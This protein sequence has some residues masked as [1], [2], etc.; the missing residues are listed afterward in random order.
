MSATGDTVVVTGGLVL[1]VGFGS[2][3]GE[4]TVAVFVIVPL[5]GAVTVNVRLLDWPGFKLPN[6]QLATPAFV[7]PPL[8]ALTNTIFVGS[9][10]LATTLLAVDGPE[11]VTVIV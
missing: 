7:V 11:L 2:P 10:S 5:T 4:P 8:L 1:F 3:V 6:D 9:T